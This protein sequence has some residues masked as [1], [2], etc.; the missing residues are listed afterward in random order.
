MKTRTR[1]TSITA[2][3]LSLFI[4]TA[5]LSAF[6]RERDRDR[7]NPPIIRIIKKLSKFFGIVPNNDFPSPPKP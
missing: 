1:I 6:P 4:L 2:V 5:P 3:A 7:D